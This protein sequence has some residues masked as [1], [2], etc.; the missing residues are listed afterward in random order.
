MCLPN[1]P[2]VQ[3]V[4]GRH[5]QTCYGGSSPSHTDELRLQL[6]TLRW[7]ASCEEA[8]QRSNCEVMLQQAVELRAER[9]QLGVEVTTLEHE[10]AASRTQAARDTV[11][12]GQNN[13]GLLEKLRA[14]QARF[15]T[16]H[17][18]LQELG[19][20]AVLEDDPDAAL[21]EM[22]A[23]CR[24][25]QEEES[26][27]AAASL[28]S[29]ELEERLQARLAEME[30]EADS[31]MR[32]VKDGRFVA[33]AKYETPADVERLR[34]EVDLLSSKVAMLNNECGYDV[35]LHFLTSEKELPRLRLAEA[36][37]RR[38]QSMHAQALWDRDRLERDFERVIRGLE[39]QEAQQ[40][41]RLHGMHSEV[42][43]AK[44]QGEE[45]LA[46]LREGDVRLAEMRRDEGETDEFMRHLNSQLLK[47]EEERSTLRK[48]LR[49]AKPGGAT[50]SPLAN[51]GV[52]V[53]EES[54]QWLMQDRRRLMEE[55]RDAVG[56]DEREA[57]AA[58]HEWK[59]LEEDVER[60]RE[61]N[62]ELRLE[63]CALGPLL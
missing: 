28:A 45:T 15:E 50:P 19:A 41:L 46:A 26:E 20:T 55:C 13:L 42:R 33:V 37:R 49:R 4:S 53:Q 8:Q 48:S 40:R 52:D 35:Q 29:E 63:A 32:K 39:E 9:R 3:Q 54:L 44:A 18:E 11:R 30:A 23:D 43:A 34:R 16:E 6:A 56:R 21:R 25:F 57:Q 12:L 22:E 17:L 60:A 38:L 7:K 24:H 5:L 14:Q 2:H 27:W 51:M 1:S 61:R 10:A 36:E 31:L 59:C 47:L 62:A 58:E